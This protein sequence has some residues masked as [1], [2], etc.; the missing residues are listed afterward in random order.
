[1]LYGQANI[2]DEKETSRD[3]NGCV[4]T[5]S[6][7]NI[8]CPLGQNWQV[9]K[10]G[11]VKIEIPLPN[12]KCDGCT[13]ALVNTTLGESNPHHYILTARHCLPYGNNPDLSHWKFYWHY[14]APECNPPYS[15]I[16]E[17]VTEGAR[18][19]V[20]GI[21]NYGDFALLELFDDP[22]EAWDVTPYYLGWDASEEQ[23]GSRKMIYH[24]DGKDKKILSYSYTHGDYGFNKG[25]DINY[26]SCPNVYMGCAGCKLNAGNLL[27]EG[28]SSGAPLLSND[29]KLIVG[30]LYGGHNCDCGY[31][32]TPTNC[33][34]FNLFCKFRYAWKDDYCNADS[35]NRLK[36]WLDPVNTGQQT[37]NGRSVCQKTIRLWHSYPRATYHAVDS[38]ISKQEIDSGLTVS[39]KAGEEIVLLDGFH[40]SLGSD[41]SASIESL[42]CNGTKSIT[43]NEGND[44]EDI[45][46]FNASLAPLQTP[47]KINLF[48]NPNTGT[49]QLETNFALTEIAY[50]KVIDMIGTTVYEVKNLFSNTIQL[51]PFANGLYFVVATLKD[52]S[53]LREKVVIQR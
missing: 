53:L 22:S 49:F 39:Y 51:P 14:E 34:W 27:V 38:I 37:L 33:S 13:G 31:P 36:D 12:G 5:G 45:E 10:N 6:Y 1:M 28:G 23:S 25:N 50:L 48:P 32:V 7:T 40:A 52:G 30:L 43:N 35:T 17:I 20:K 19:V 47:Y 18:L 46:T 42:D 11:V 44:D 4:N 26:Y 3:E 9:E 15:A 29:N 24:P 8:N 41:F 16:P 2:E 21:S